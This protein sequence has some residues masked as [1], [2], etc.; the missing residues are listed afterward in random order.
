MEINE[1]EEK[2]REE[3]RRKRRGRRMRRKKPEKISNEKEDWVEGKENAKWLEEKDL[4]GN[5]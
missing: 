1:E 2:R 4:Q 5:R 3:M